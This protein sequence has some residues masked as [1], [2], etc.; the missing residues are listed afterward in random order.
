[1][2]FCSGAPPPGNFG[3]VKRNGGDLFIHVCKRGNDHNFRVGLPSVEPCIYLYGHRCGVP[4]FLYVSTVTCVCRNRK[5]LQRSCPHDLFPFS[6]AAYIYCIRIGM[7]GVLSVSVWYHTGSTTGLSYCR[8]RNES[9]CMLDAADWKR[10]H[11]L[12]TA[13]LVGDLLND[14]KMHKCAT[15]LFRWLVYVYTLYDL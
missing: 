3:R 8:R 5:F 10:W 12:F 11:R 14:F 2:G 4:R 1:M 9:L 15:I 6:Y 13:R 7:Y